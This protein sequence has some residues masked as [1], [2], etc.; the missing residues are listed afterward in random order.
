MNKLKNIVLMIALMCF[1]LS[2]KKEKF[3]LGYYEMTMFWSKTISGVKKDYQKKRT[4]SI[5]NETKTDIEIA[6]IINDSVSTNSAVKLLKKGR[7]ITG[8]LPSSSDSTYIE[9]KKNIFNNTITGTFKM[10]YQIYSQGPSGASNYIQP[11]N[12]TFK[13]EK[14]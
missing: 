13:M 8:F 6:S 10:V 2:C 4:F 5:I 11:Y 14:Q 1:S 9:G 7:V 12:G 3:D